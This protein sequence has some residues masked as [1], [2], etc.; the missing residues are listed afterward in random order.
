MNNNIN[1][2]DYQQLCAAINMLRRSN[3]TLP[4]H[5][6][7]VALLEAH[8]MPEAE[9]IALVARWHKKYRKIC[10]EMGLINKNQAFWI[11]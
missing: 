10:E 3:I 6:I 5:E 8:R 1:S 4:Y 9:F 7:A 2:F 11:H